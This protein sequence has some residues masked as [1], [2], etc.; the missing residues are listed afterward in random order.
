[1]QLVPDDHGPYRFD[2]YRP[3]VHLLSDPNAAVALRGYALHPTCWQ[4]AELTRVLCV[5][6]KDT[7]PVARCPSAA[8]AALFAARADG[9]QAASRATSHE[10]TGS[11][12][13]G[14]KRQGSAR[15]TPA[16]A[17]QPPPKAIARAR[18]VMIFPGSWNAR[19]GRHRF[20][21]A[22][23]SACSPAH[24]CRMGQ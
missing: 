8:C 6:V 12:A 13:T 4:R 20:S 3:P 9:A 14:P 10:I 22:D 24:Q 1:M 7:W 11:E 16:S 18:S 2:M 17:R 23:S 15:N 21:A 19:P 5:R